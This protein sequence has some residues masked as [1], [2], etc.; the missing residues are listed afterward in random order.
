[1][2]ADER[3]IYFYLKPYRQIYI[4]AREIARRADGKKRFL[5]EPEWAKRVL[6]RMVERGILETDPAGHY[7]I[8]PVER[9]GDKNKRWVSPQIQKI[10]QASGKEFHE[11]AMSDEELDQFY[12]GL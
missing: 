7:R 8:K 5:A 10:L 9:G 1:M 12:D 4:S 6:N 11:I 3:A 2:D